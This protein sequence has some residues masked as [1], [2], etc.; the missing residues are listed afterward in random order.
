VSTNAVMDTNTGR[1]RRNRSWPE[2]VKREIVA[3]SLVP[4][5]SVS[6]VARRY[7]VNAN[8]VFKWRKSFGNDSRP[9]VASQ[10]IPVV[11]QAEHASVAAPPS[12]V[13]EKVEIDVAGKYRVR[14]WGNFD[15]QV[16][17]RVL[18]LLER[19]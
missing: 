15:E 1:R 18:D 7:D 11:V 5:A 4:G 17:R 6:L 3:A 12:L 16:L 2:A 9:P 19:R 13:G 14:F 10:M 8:Q